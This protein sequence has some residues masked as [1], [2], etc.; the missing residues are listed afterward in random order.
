MLC[1]AML[2]ARSELGITVIFVMLPD[3][4]RATD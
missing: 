3:S 2:S 1:Y 4:P